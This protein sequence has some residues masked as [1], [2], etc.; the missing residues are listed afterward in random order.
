[1]QRYGAA[2]QPRVV[3]HGLFLNDFDENLQFVEWEHSGKE[4][5]RAWYH[6]QNLG[7]LGYRLYKRFR[8]YRLVRSLLRANRSQTY[9]VS[10][11]GLNLYMSPTGW[12]VK[13]T[14]RA[15]DAEHLAV[16]QQVLLDEQ[17]AARDMGAQFV[18]LL[19]PFKEQVYWDDMLRHAPH[20]TD[21]DVDG[22]FRVLAEFC[23][24]R[25]I[26]YVDVTDALR[27][28]ARAGEQLYF[29]MDAHWNRRGNAV[30]A[31]AV[32]AALREQGVL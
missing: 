24:D 32:L 21:V 31:S 30:A 4:N 18:A 28:H 29:S 6:E 11:N 14:K 25:G 27:A 16:M 7:E 20:L 5:L 15:T 1:M 23:R 3:F 22:P 12:W 2:F 9:H 10:D 13:A 26:P 8:T 19:F 17:R